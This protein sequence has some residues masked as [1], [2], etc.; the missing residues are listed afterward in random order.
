LKEFSSEELARYNGKKGSPAYIAYKG[1]VYDVT[2]SFLW[3]N[4]SHAVLH[5]AGVDLTD[6]LEQ[7]P[8]SADFLE[9][10]PVVGMLQTKDLPRERSF[11]DFP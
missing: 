4:G 6:A 1:K 11:R 7:A 10:F 9:R 2:S 3:R 5:S 8:H